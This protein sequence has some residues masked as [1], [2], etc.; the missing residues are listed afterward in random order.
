MP[1]IDENSVI[2]AVLAGDA[3][4]FEQIVRVYQDTVYNHALF[5]LQNPQDALDAAQDTFL[6]AY[7][8]LRSFRRESRFSV[9]LYRITHNCCVDILR[10]R[11]PTVPLESEDGAVIDIS[12]PRPGP[13]ESVV[14]ADTAAAVRRAL[15]Q[16]PQEFREVLLLREF[17]GLSYAEIARVVG[18][19]TAT[20]KT[21]IFRARKKLAAIL[22]ENGILSDLIPSDT[23][24]EGGASHA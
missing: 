18:I 7:T 14:R 22:L 5:M 6:N 9:W 10:R 19:E 1:Q 21:R 4:A 12:D 15:S 17:G 16:L 2:R 13:E 11:P 24:E 23:A 3:N 20:V 8:G